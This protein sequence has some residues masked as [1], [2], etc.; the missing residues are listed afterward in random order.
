[1][2]KYLNVLGLG[3]NFFMLYFVRERVEGEECISC[4]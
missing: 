1:M 2:Y 4:F 3:K